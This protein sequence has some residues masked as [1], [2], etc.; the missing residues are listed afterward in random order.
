[1]EG[2][3][4]V[5]RA[6]PGILAQDVRKGEEVVQV[7]G[8]GGVWGCKRGYGAERGGERGGVSWGRLGAFG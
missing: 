3:R 7:G 1:M 2:C 4:L 6:S 5:K 8:S